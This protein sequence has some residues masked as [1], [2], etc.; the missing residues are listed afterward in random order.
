MHGKRAEPIIR[1]KLSH[2]VMERLL[3]EIESGSLSPGSRLPSEREL[4]E[5]YGVGRPAVREALQGLESMGL[6]TIT[7]GERAR[8]VELSTSDMFGQIDRVARHLLSTSPT[9]LEHL[10]E[11]RLLFEV[12]MV[13]IAAERATREDVARLEEIL[14]EMKAAAGDPQRFVQADIAFH[15]QVASI[16][17]NPICAAVSEAMLQW[18]REFHSELV[19]APGNEKVTIS[20]HARVLRRIAAKDPKG[21]AQAMTAHLTRASKLYRSPARE[22]TS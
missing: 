16:S 10:K 22:Q 2:E 5:M 15:K 3:K 8:V 4:M 12:G 21:A 13:R 18:L 6:I 1:K 9:T 20:E 19:R 17:R 14:A 11:A 7:H